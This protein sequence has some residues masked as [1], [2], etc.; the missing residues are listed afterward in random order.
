MNNSTIAAI[1][2]VHIHAYRPE[3]NGRGTG[4][5]APPR[6]RREAQGGVASWDPETFEVDVVLD[7]SG[8]VVGA[9]VRER[10]TGV[11]VA[12]IGADQLASGNLRAGI[13]FERRG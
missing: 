12:R 7:E 4:H 8:A 10:A 9:V 5:Q 3:W 2:P 6:K 1:S 13:L 11:V